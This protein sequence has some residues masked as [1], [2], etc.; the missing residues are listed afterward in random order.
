VTALQQER[1]QLERLHQGQLD[2]ASPAAGSKPRPLAPNS[3][4][5]GVA[6]A[7]PPLQ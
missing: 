5:S 3:L 4:R 6:A 2:S 1:V 7:V